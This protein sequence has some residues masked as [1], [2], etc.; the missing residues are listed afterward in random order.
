MLGYILI[1]V[2]AI[3]MIFGSMALWKW[4]SGGGS[5]FDPGVV[6]RTGASKNERQFLDLYFFSLV[7][8]PLLGGAIFIVFGLCKLP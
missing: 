2:G 8:V 4:N 6:D 5:W 1:A 3:A 7:I